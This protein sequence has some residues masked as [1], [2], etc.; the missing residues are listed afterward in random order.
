MAADKRSIKTSEIALMVEGSLR[1]DGEVSISRVSSLEMADPES[2]GFL[3]GPKFKEAALASRAGAIILSV[4]LEKDVPQIIVSDPYASFVKLMGWFHPE[5][6]PEP[7]V[8][9]S[10]QVAEDVRLGA[11][12][13]IGPAAVIESGARVGDRTRVGAGCILGR[14]VEIGPD[15][16]VH[17]SVTLYKGVKI[18]SATVIHS[19]TV[20]GADG[21]G[22]ILSGEGHLKKPQVGGVVIGDRVE[23]GANCTVD[24]A[25]LD[26]TV[27]GDGTKID[28]LVHLAHNVRV[29]KN[30]VILASTTCGGSTVIGDNCIISG[31]CTISD[32]V[33]IGAGALVIGGSGVHEDVAPGARVMGYPAMEFSLAKRVYGRLKGLPDLFKRIRKL[34]KLA[35]DEK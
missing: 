14:D 8:H 12:V 35:E 27:V 29:G 7:G 20:I 23:I 26:S 16:V 22:Y 19:G 10:A 3:G 2:I 1:G 25:M 6:K 28:N 30:C 9:P 33:T 13:S 5:E 24:R 31:N 18:G 4:P 15:C 32:N 34:E 21:F 17:A 11:D